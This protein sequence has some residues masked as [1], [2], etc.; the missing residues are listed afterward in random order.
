MNAEH[1]NHL[2]LNTALKILTSSPLC[3]FGVGELFHACFPQIVLAAG[4][5]PDILCDN[6]PSKWGRTF[7]GIPCISPDQLTTVASNLRIIICIRHYESVRDQLHSLGFYNLFIAR[8][9]RAYDHLSGIQPLDSGHDQTGKMLDLRGKWAV[10]TGASRGIGR[11]IAL[12]LARIGINVACHARHPSHLQ[13]VLQECRNHDVNVK[14]L[15][16][17]LVTP[18]G[19]T[20]LIRQIEDD[21]PAPDIL[22][23]NA[24]HS[25]QGW[26]DFGK[27]SHLNFIETYAVNT[28]APIRLTLAV[29]PGM[30]ERG[31]GRIIN[32]SSNIRHI[33]L[34]MPYAC[35]KAAL[36]K[37]VFDMTPSLAKTGIMM[38]LLD[39]GWLRTD[40]G[41]ETAPNP[42]E[43]VLPGALLGAVLDGDLNGRWIVA[44][45]YVGMILEAA[46]AKAF[47][48]G[49]AH[50]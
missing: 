14:M 23:N 44:Q 3:L 35:S 15:H 36:D 10:V 27:I 5:R 19:V 41:G 24:G 7:F 20:R 26:N 18:E 16:A 42:V 22:Y 48:I 28:I 46:V 38:S 9:D 4:G 49:V 8:F 32:V 29:L 39:P 12:A 13:S 2:T 34:S 1:S 43:N 6:A 50:A 31:F 17:D 45:D 37:F 47:F 25:T 40:M 11:Q 33:P 21:M 30:R